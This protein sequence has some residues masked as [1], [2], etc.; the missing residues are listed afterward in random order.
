ML[1]RRSA[2]FPRSGWCR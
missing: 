2:D 1:N